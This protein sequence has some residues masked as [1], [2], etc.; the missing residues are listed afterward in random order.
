MPVVSHGSSSHSTSVAFVQM[1]YWNWEKR[2]KQF[3]YEYNKTMAELA[4]NRAQGLETA[5]E[6]TKETA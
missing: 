4:D 3:Y 2:V 6:T 5:D 1:Y